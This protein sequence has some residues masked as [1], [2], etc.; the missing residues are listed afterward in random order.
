MSSWQEGLCGKTG[1]EAESCFPFF[2]LRPPGRVEGD[3]LV[4][5]PWSGAPFTFSPFSWRCCA[6]L[7]LWWLRSRD[8][9]GVEVLSYVEQR[10]IGPGENQLKQFH[11][12]YKCSET[13]VNLKRKQTNF[14]NMWFPSISQ[15]CS[16][17][18]GQR[19]KQPILAGKGSGIL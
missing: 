15:T 14:E 6:W 5:L 11:S 4:L 10:H 16:W 8:I 7:F 18:E 2:L 13:S 19:G 9:E 1:G 12:C 3:T 17:K